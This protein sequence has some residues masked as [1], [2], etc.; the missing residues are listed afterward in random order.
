MVGVLDE[1]HLMWS[2]SI[3]IPALDEAHGIAETLQRLQPIR[4]AG[5]EVILIDGG[6]RDATVA[7]AAPLVDRVVLSAPGRAIQMNA[8]AALASGSAI[9]FLHADTYLPDNACALAREALART[10]WGRFDVEIRGAPRMLG[11]IAWLMNWRSRLTGIAT[12]DQA[13][14]MR[15]QTFQEVGG[16]PLILLMEDIELSSRLRRIA[17]PACLVAKVSTSGRRWESRGLWRTVLLMW[18]LRAAY[19]L[20]VSPDFLARIYR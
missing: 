8:G 3:L 18:G 1:P 4:A 11:Q 16:F 6:S 15:R 13:M 10:V 20:G 14:F 9:L 2:L 5:H 12:G 19:A 7:L 17:R